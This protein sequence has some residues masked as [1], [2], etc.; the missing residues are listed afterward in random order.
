MQQFVD[1]KTKITD[2]GSEEL[3]GPSLLYGH[4]PGGLRIG[5]VHLPV[6]AS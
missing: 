4:V 6:T 1:V 2:L 5:A 3:A